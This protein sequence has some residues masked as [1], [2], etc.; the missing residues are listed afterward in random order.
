MKDSF[1]SHH[2]PWKIE[3]VLIKVV[4]FKVRCFTPSLHFKIKDWLSP[5]PALSSMSHHWHIRWPE[6]WQHL[7]KNQEAQERANWLSTQFI[8][9]GPNHLCF[10]GVGGFPHPYQCAAPWW[11]K[12]DSTSVLQLPGGDWDI[13]G[14]LRRKTSI[15]ISLTNF[16]QPIPLNHRTNWSPGKRL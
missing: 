6:P 15:L 2:V 8:C 4:C 3:W 16:F 13:R 1:P 5:G 10:S 12:I 9:Y 7:N 11:I 14:E